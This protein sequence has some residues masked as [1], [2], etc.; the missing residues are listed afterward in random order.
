MDLNPFEIPQ[1]VVIRD[2]IPGK[3]ENSI[4]IM[5]FPQHSFLGPMTCDYLVQL[6]RMKQVGYLDSDELRTTATTFFGIVSPSIRV[7]M[8]KLE[9]GE[10]DSIV[11][12]SSWIE[13][14]GYET[15]HE[16]LRSRRILA[17]AHSIVDWIKE[18]EIDIVL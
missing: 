15:L 9:N 6:L 11:V 3:L 1:N 18:K 4:L 13:L 8:R 17:Y 10:Y 5:G 7:H 12:I 14:G 16:M 2:I